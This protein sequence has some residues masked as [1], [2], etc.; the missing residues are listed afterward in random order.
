MSA[1]EYTTFLDFHETIK[2]QQAPERLA[3][4]MESLFRDQVG[5]ALCDI[6]TLIPW[7]RSMNVNF[8][9]KQDVEEFCAASIFQGP[10]GKITQVFAYKP[11]SD[12][13]KFYYKRVE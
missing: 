9:E 6:Q 10:R 1:I 8:Y 7:Y 13:K 5:N 11:G 12:C 3:E 2:G 4:T